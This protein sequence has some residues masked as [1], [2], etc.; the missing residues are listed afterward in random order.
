[1]FFYCSHY[2]RDPQNRNGVCVLIPDCWERKPGDPSIYVTACGPDCVEI[3]T[4][5]GSEKIGVKIQDYI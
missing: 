4:E 5:Q 1:M 3:E 2:V